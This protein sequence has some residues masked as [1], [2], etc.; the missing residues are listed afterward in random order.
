MLS[1]Q[2]CSPVLWEK[3]VR[4]MIAAGADT[5]VEI[6]P[7]RTL[8]GPIARIDPSVRVIAGGE[9][10]QSETILDEVKIC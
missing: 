8:C 10:E 6:G 1:K 7:G 2:I 4:N 5:F 9:L 3:L